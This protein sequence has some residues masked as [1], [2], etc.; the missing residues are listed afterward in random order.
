M[1]S[2]DGQGDLPQCHFRYIARGNAYGID[3]GGRIEIYDVRKV[4]PF[5]EQLRIQTTA[6]KQHKSNAVFGKP[7]VTDLQ[8]EVVQ[9]F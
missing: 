8:I 9:F 4:L 3:G 6:G 5:K 2:S 7:S 1:H